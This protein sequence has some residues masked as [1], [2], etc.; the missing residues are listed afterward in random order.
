MRL[1]SLHWAKVLLRVPSFIVLFLYIADWN[2]F[3]VTGCDVVV[4]SRRTMSRENADVGY[5][6]QD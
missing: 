4:K 3:A 1:I 5:G 2:L 6:N